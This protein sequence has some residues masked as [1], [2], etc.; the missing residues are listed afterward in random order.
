MTIHTTA[1]DN[2]IVFDNF[3]DTEVFEDILSKSEYV[4]WKYCEVVSESE[5]NPVE[6]FMTWNIY[7]EGHVHFDPMQ[8]MDIVDEQ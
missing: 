2:I 6:R 8:L 3:F 4:P 5:G 7:E 1:I